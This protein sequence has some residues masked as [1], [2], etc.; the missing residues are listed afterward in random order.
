VYPHLFSPLDIGQ[1]TLRNRVM[2]SAHD[3]HFSRDGAY[4]QRD[5]DYQVARARGGAALLVT[6]NRAVHPTSVGARS[7]L[8]YTRDIIS[9]D[10]RL[11]GMVHDH[12]A[13]I[14]AQLGHTG[15]NTADDA[16]DDLRVNWGPSSFASPINGNAVKEMDSDDIAELIRGFGLSA[17]IAREGGFDGIELHFAHSYL[18]H[19]F[20]SPFY[21]RRTDDYGGTPA[22]Q[23]RL[24]LEI[25]AEIRARVGADYILGARLGLSDFLAGGVT[26]QDSIETARQLSNTAG[27]DYF[28]LS[29]GGGDKRFM[30]ATSDI[31]DGWLVA[32]AAK[33]KAAF[34]STP[35]FVVGGIKHAAMAEEILAE[36][37]ADMVAM[38]RA[39]I[40]D[41]ELA[42]K[43]REGREDEIYHC[44]R[45]NQG[46][47]AGAFSKGQPVSCT[48]N[49]LAGREGM[50]ASRATARVD[51]PK[52]WLVVGGGPAG[53]KAAETLAV[54]G[55]SVTVVE[56]QAQLGGQVNLITATP[57]RA[58]FGWLT[59]DLG[60]QLE[61][62]AV[63]VRLG[64]EATPDYVVDFA[65]DGVIVATGA[66]PDASGRCLAV[67]PFAEPL[68]RSTHENVVTL[69]D[70]ITRSRPVG[71]RVVVLD[72]DGTR[73]AAG[74]VEVLLDADHDVELVTRFGSL[75][76]GT[77]GTL[78]LPFVYGRL[79]S[80]GLRYRV[81]SWA[82]A[83]S[84][85]KVTVF[86]LYSRRTDEIGADSVV[87]AT[88]R[89]ADDSLYRRLKA[90][91]QGRFTVQRVGDC[92]APRKLDHAIYEGFLAGAEILD[93]SLRFI[94]EG[95][96]ERIES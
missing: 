22:G 55:H 46:C 33:F 63:E 11:V 17:E 56:R 2:Q 8:G 53:L 81:N 69:W 85:T 13:A 44:I 49:P 96:L 23:R 88:Q 21:N 27:I 36:G 6:G 89:H 61:R 9:A 29:T 5:I 54:R 20:L 90:V 77:A 50:L 12:G 28:S 32:D 92:V 51:L 24:A 19:E 64:V 48:V 86:D 62:L 76:P 78:D 59:R 84:D 39:Q 79:M 91:R 41:P 7:S 3:K 40:A 87:L 74:M 31:A 37:K 94:P 38:T 35:V 83:I 57:G 71:K 70:V 80:K 60:R 82:S 93:G 47:I 1:I 75:F 34:A 66:Y 72:D 73:A 68:V 16:A 25:A 10:R 30:V 26:L 15:V 58:E 45:G 52:R 43:I 4:S 67:D 95:S 18:I 14:F 65:A 42:R